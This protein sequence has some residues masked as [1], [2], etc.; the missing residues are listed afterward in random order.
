MEYQQQI[1]GQKCAVSLVGSFTH[2]D[3]NA[4][5]AIFDAI[6]QDSV[7]DIEIDFAD[8][9]FIDSSG[10]G[11]LLLVRG[12]SRKCQKHLVLLHPNGQVKK[13]FEVSRYYDLFEIQE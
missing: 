7:K 10:L 9:D 3:H 2:H 6:S 1:D 8:T 4:F 11:I 12:E 13:M 5:K